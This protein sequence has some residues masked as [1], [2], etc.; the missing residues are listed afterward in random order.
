MATRLCFFDFVYVF[1]KVL[2]AGFFA[3]VF[4]AMTTMS[5]AQPDVIKVLEKKLVNAQFDTAR[6]NLQNALSLE[7]LTSDPTE[8]VN[9]ANKALELSRKTNYVEGEI[10]ALNRLGENEFRRSE[11]AN[12]ILLAMQSLR[13]AEQQH[14]TINVAFAYRL[15]GL[16]NTLG[17]K[18]YDL[19]LQYQLKALEIFKKKNN[20]KRLASLYGNITW[21]YASMNQNLTEAKAM[22]LRGIRIADSLSDLRLLSYN[23]NSLGL[24]FKQQNQLDSALAYLDK[25]IDAAVSVGD[26]GVIVYNQIIK[27]DILYQMN[28]YRGAIEY[29]RNADLQAK[30]LKIVGLCRDANAGLALAFEKIGNYESAYRSLLISSKIKDSLLVWEASEKGQLIKLEFEQEKQHEKINRLEAENVKSK[31]EKIYFLTAG[32]VSFSALIAVVVLMVMNNRQRAYAN[33]ILVEKNEEIATQNEQLKEVNQVKNRLFSIIGHD[34]RSPLNS[35]KGMLGMVVRKEVTVEEFGTFAP[36]LHRQVI[37]VGE[38][39]DN[40]LLWSQSQMEGW[41]TK[42]V[43]IN[44]FEIVEKASVL[45]KEA[46]A[47]KVIALMN[48]TSKNNLAFADEDQIELIIRNLIHNAIKFTP[49]GGRIQLTSKE[50]NNFIELLICDTGIGMGQEKI[51]NLFNG[52]SNSSKGTSGEKG[53]GLGLLLC[54]EMIENNGGKISVTSIENKGTCF[55]V[56]IPKA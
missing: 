26:K 24:I 12:A 17:L 8:S 27:G 50:N 36:K 29:Y 41:A 21:I 42:P 1:L 40:L 48:S 19:A 56:V 3:G 2:K 5:A 35:L 11:H 22:A 31:T 52:S 34:L 47:E 53:T 43:A 23:F 15:L 28:N 4:L 44:L 30:A 51:S 37:G 46:A 32:I 25:S 6:I 45:F 39:L 38:T 18:Q 16:I 14:D 20:P 10:V 33:H 13:L 49:K 7:Y 55:K 9:L 54:N